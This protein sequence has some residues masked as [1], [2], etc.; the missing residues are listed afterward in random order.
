MTARKAKD[1]VKRLTRSILRKFPKKLNF[2][3]LLN[4]VLKTPLKSLKSFRQHSIY[5]P[6]SSRPENSK[7]LTA[8]NVSKFRDFFVRICLHSDWI[9]KFTEKISVFSPNTGKYGPERLRLGHFS[10]SA[11]V[12][13]ATSLKKVL[14]SNCFQTPVDGCFCCLLSQQNIFRSFWINFRTYHLHTCDTSCY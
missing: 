12:S 3:C 8:W 14:Y 6:E 7:T 5:L 2:R 11:S 13:T 4:R 9:Q 1:S 10:R